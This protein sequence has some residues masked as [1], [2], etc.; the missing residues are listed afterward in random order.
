MAAEAG[1]NIEPVDTRNF[2]DDAVVI[3]RHLV[4]TA[5][6]E[7]QIQVPEF[8]QPLN[9]GRHE[10]LVEPL[11]ITAESKSRRFAGIGL[12]DDNLVGRRSPPMNST[13]INDDGKFVRPWPG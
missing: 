2:I 9:E 8:G 10:L 13:G 4:Q 12:C 1:G 7:N 6:A 3:R 11:E 5:P